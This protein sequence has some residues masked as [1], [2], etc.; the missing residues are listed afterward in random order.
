MKLQ[1]KR[2]KRAMD[3]ASKGERLT[4]WERTLLIQQWARMVCRGRW[5]RQ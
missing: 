4:L 3:K 2:Q 5:V 1:S